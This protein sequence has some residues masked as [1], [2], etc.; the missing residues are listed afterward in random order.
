MATARKG[1][2]AKVKD[3]VTG[4][5]D[6]KPKRKSPK[7]V[8]AGR[9]AAVTAKANKAVKSAKAAARKAVKAVTGARKTASKKSR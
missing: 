5:F 1:V 7:R 9:K 2:V 6:D 3:A 8:Q 4:L